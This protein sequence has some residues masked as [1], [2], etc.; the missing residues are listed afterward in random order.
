M[1]FL[2]FK[3]PEKHATLL[4]K[5]FIPLYIEH[6]QFLVKRAGWIVTKIYSHYTL[7]QESFRKDSIL[8]NQKSRQEE[9]RVFKNL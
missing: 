9:K 6:I 3:L 7:D 2:R 5:T 1:K 8:M 4:E